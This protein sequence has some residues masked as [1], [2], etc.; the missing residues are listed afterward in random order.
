M[1]TSPFRLAP[2]LP[3]T[4]R[5][6]N[7]D[8]RIARTVARDTS[9]APERVARALTWGAD[10]KVLLVLA[11]AGWVASRGRGEPLRRAGNH[12][13]LVA[14]A[15]S[16]LPHGIKLLFNQT[17]PDRKTVLGHVHGIA[18]SGKREDAFPSG[19]ALHMGA[20]ASAA[21]ALPAG[22]RRAIRALAVGLSLTRVVVLAHWA[23]DVAAGFALGAILERMLRL[24]SGY[25]HGR[26]G[27]DLGP[28]SNLRENA[29]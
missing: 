18:F 13:V 1:R 29:K 5:P 11:A 25:P 8:V 3:I 28:P 20:M 24:C 17:R 26:P 10:E 16:L 23:S 22:P 14:V 12:A 21:G 6:T 2:R 27:I 19:H 9:P 4:I 15:A 7:T